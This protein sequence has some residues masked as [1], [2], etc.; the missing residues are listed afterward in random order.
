LADNYFSHLLQQKVNNTNKVIILIT[1]ILFIIT[2]HLLA[3][4]DNFE[5][6]IIGI[7]D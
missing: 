7:G 1:F 3:D 2:F 5:V 4:I 6:K